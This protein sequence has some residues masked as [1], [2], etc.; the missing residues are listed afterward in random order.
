MKGKC[1]RWEATQVLALQLS[2]LMTL[3]KLLNL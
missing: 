1:E 3:D 2:G